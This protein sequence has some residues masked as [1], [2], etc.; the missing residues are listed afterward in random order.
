MGTKDRV[1]IAQL[2]SVPGKV[3]VPVHYELRI[4]HRSGREIE[5]ELRVVPTESDGR[6]T[7]LCFLRDMFRAAPG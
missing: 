4:I 7:L 5:C 6:T 3:L 1:A 2:L